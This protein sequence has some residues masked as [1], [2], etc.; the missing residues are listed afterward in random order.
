V[1]I[2]AYSRSLQKLLHRQTIFFFSQIPRLGDGDGDVD[3]DVDA[4]DVQMDDQKMK[5]VEWK[6]VR[7]TIVIT[8]IPL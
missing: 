7:L 3:V 5:K 4:D 2:E 1:K 6:A 8:Y